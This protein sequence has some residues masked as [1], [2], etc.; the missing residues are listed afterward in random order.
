[1]IVIMLGEF[2]YLMLTAAVRDLHVT[3]PDQFVTDVRTPC[4]ELWE[5]NPYLTPIDESP[6]RGTRS[7][8]PPLSRHAPWLSVP[9]HKAPARVW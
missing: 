5:H 3:Y 6:S 4:P 1:M 2:E 8:T 9:T 7:A